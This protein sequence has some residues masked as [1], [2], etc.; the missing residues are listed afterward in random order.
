MSSPIKAEVYADNRMTGTVQPK[1]KMLSLFTAPHFVPNPYA[2]VVFYV[3][4]KDSKE[5]YVPKRLKPCGAGGT[6]IRLLILRV[7]SN[8][9]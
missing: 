3:M 6:S 7:S 9:L 1:M 8:L 5:H 4:E 2:V